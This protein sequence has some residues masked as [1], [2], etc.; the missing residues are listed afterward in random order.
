MRIWLLYACLITVFMFPVSEV[1]AQTD[2]SKPGLTF[3]KDIAPILYAKC[4][5]CHREGTVAP[6][7]L[8]NYTTAR[9]WARAIK[10]KVLSR[11]MPPWHADPQYG[12]YKNDPTLSQEEINMIAAWV[13]AGSPEGNPN[14]LPAQPV[15]QEGWLIGTPDV[16]FQAPEPFKLPAEGILEYQD[17]KFSTNFKEDKWVERVQVLH[18]N[19]ATVH[20]FGLHARAPNPR[21]DEIEYPGVAPGSSTAPLAPPPTFGTELTA[22]GVGTA[23]PQYDDGALLVR[24]GSELTL[25]IHY[26]TTGSPTSDHTRVG[27]VFADQPPAN[28]LHSLPI[29]NLGFEI[30][31]GA[32]AHEVVAEVTFTDNAKLWSLFP[33]MHLRGKAFKYELFYPD[34]HSKVLLSVPKF[35]FNWQH[36]YFLEEP[37]E[38]PAG[39]RLVCTAW[40]DNSPANRFN[41]DPSIPVVWGEQTWDEMMIGFM[42]Y[43]LEP[44]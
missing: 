23:P 2:N 14:D 7:S 16:V 25:Q 43:S 3:T 15:F 6:M 24:A 8:L 12:P 27:I 34:G 18:S 4:V 29:M 37:I 21:P 10:Q 28:Q 38:V 31:A 9:P 22:A 39:S 30:P 32:P 26:V 36:D 41:P 44:A 42:T 35:D 11:E 40:F 1:M 13:D 33:H 19:P 5:K 20:H 17:F